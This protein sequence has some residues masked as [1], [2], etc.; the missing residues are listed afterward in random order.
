METDAIQNGLHDQPSL[1][2]LIAKHQFF[3]TTEEK[4]EEVNV[5]SIQPLTE[6]RE[7]RLERDGMF[8]QPGSNAA[9]VAGERIALQPSGRPS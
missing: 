1:G 6:L 5:F 3:E 8:F 4:I 9:P 7:P 2:G